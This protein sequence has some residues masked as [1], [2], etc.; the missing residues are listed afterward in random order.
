M[1]RKNDDKHDIILRLIDTKKEQ[2]TLIK[3]KASVFF[4]ANKIRDIIRFQKEDYE[5]LLNLGSNQ[6]THFNLQGPGHQRN[7]Q[8]AL[9]EILKP[10]FYT[11]TSEQLPVLNLNDCLIAECI[12]CQQKVSYSELEQDVFTHSLSNIKDTESL[13]MAIIRRYSK[14]MPNLTK[15]NILDLGVSVTKLKIIKKADLKIT[16]EV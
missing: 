15:Q 16:K 2:G 11:E 14:T 1:Q 4:R 6:L 5:C 13:K 12:S 7:Q 9:M 3:K 10:G 8:Y